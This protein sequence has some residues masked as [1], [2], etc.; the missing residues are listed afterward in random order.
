MQRAK[1]PSA[2]PGKAEN[3]HDIRRLR[4][5]PARAV[6]AVV[7]VAC[8]G[9][10]VTAQLLA[11]AGA[12]AQ[13]AG[14]ATDPLLMAAGASGGDPPTKT[15]AKAPLTHTAAAHTPAQPR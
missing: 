3:L 7:T 5:P 6:R 15:P 9:S 2:G 8:L 4:F 1:R 12:T 14:A 11:F 10:L 13:P